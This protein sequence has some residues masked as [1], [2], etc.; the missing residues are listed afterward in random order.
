MNRDMNQFDKDFKSLVDS[1]EASYS[2]DSWAKLEKDLPKPKLKPWYFVAASVLILAVI[3][4][5][6]LQDNSVKDKTQNTSVQESV[7][8]SESINV[9]SVSYTSILSF[10]VYITCP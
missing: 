7:V 10:F 5:V 9:Q 3:S 6:V 4:F 8:K 2:A 1:Y